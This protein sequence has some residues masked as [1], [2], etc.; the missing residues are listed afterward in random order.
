LRNARIPTVRQL[1]LQKR[2]LKYRRHAG[3][4]TTIMKKTL[5]FALLILAYSS[6]AAPDSTNKWTFHFQQS[7][8]NQWH[9]EEKFAY[10]GPSSLDSNAESRL[11]LTTTIYLGRRLWKGASVYFSPEATAGNGLSFT[12]GIAGFP[13]GEIYR[14]GN[15]TPTPFIAR[16]YF[17][18]IFPLKHT[19]YE[20]TEDGINQLGGM[21]PTSRIVL[22][23]GKYCLADFFDANIYD[24]D[25]RSQFLNW[26][27]MAQGAWDFPADT[28]GYT[29]GIEVELVRPKWSLMYALVQMPATANNLN[30]DWDYTKENGQT[31]QYERKISVN[32][33]AGAIRGSIFMN[34]CYAPTYKAA[35]SAIK[36]GD[37][38]L[39]AVLAG[40]QEPAHNPS[41]KWG[42]GIN[43]EQELSKN[44]GLFCRWS[45]N[46]GA[47]ASWA[48]TDIDQSLM[49]GLNISVNR[50]NDKHDTWGIAQV[51]NGIS[52]DHQD[53]LAAGGYTFIIG[54][55]KL[56]Y[57]PEFITETY[58]KSKVANN[59][60]LSLDY[61]LIV[62]P[63]YN[64]DRQGPVSVPGLR[65]HVEF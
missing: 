3:G 57:A 58:Y 7:M 55:G 65:V 28:R 48:F 36:A 37:S 4:N 53:Y 61:Q 46:D 39:V 27:M 41:V 44:V 63:G 62:N 30:L 14:V 20:W 42:Y 26:S 24:H 19:E 40:A 11:S 23:I 51:M 1:S 56:N 54:D 10:S 47:T 59:L 18:Q 2:I 21:Q 32:K 22:N 49:A 29:S 12:H 34:T 8:V 31:L 35:I 9:S 45:W 43:I 33:H 17:K 6:H 25:A 13:N 50:G 52:K 15:P 5:I 16:L 38:S 60:Y 64:K